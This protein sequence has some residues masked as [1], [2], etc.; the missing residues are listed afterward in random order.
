M[1][2][3]I[4][5]IC[6]VVILFIAAL[7]LCIMVIGVFLDTLKSFVEWREGRRK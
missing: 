1:T 3:Y 7:T 5:P 6:L 2:D 4:M